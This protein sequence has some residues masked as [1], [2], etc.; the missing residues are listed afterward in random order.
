MAFQFTPLSLHDVVLI[1]PTRHRDD[2]GFFSETFR[3]SA[4][5]PYVR[6]PFVQDNLARSAAGVLRGLHFQLA[7]RAQGKLIQVVRGE[8]WDVAVDIRRSS[9][10]FRRWLVLRSDLTSGLLRQKTPS[11]R[12]RTGHCRCFPRRRRSSS[13]T[14]RTSS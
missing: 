3:A 5:E 8:I 6:D 10:T 13:K 11:S 7:P 14:V 9:P 4:F 1:L 12:K 2:R